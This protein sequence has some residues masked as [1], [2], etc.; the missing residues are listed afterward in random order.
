MSALFWCFVL[1]IPSVIGDAMVKKAANGASSWWAFGAALI[2][3]VCTIGWYRVMKTTRLATIAPLYSSAILLLLV[4]LG[5]F[6]FGERLRVRDGIAVGL[7]L[8]AIYILN[9][10][11]G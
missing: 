2:Y 8:V 6:M 9:S 4:A 10:R 11:P 1:A 3:A 5:V 7:V